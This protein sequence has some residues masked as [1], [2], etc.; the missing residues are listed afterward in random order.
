MSITTSPDPLSSSIVFYQPYYVTFTAGT[1]LENAGTYVYTTDWAVTQQV[2]IGGSTDASIDWIDLSVRT[3]PFVRQKTINITGGAYPAGHLNSGRTIRIDWSYSSSY[4]TTS[5]FTVPQLSGATTYNLAPSGSLIFT[6]NATAISGLPLITI[7]LS[8]DI[9][10]TPS[11]KGLSISITAPPPPNNY[12]AQAT[13]DQNPGSSVFVVDVPDGFSTSFAKTVEESLGHPPPFTVPISSLKGDGVTVVSTYNWILDFVYP[14]VSV[15]P[16]LDTLNAYQPFSHTF[17]VGSI[18]QITVTQ[19]SDLLDYFT[20]ADGIITLS[21]ARGITTPGTYNFTIKTYD[22][23]LLVGTTSYSLTVSLPPSITVNGP[24]TA[25]YKYE[26]FTTTFSLPDPTSLTLRYSKTSGDLRTIITQVSPSYLSMA[27]TFQTTTTDPYSLIVEELD[28]DGVVLSTFSSL[29]TVGNGRFYP[30]VS[31]QNYQLYQFENISN[32]LGSN[33]VFS[34]KTPINFIYSDVSLPIG[35]SFSNI[36]S[37]TYVLKGTPSISNA[38]RN[39]QIFGSNS[40]TGKIVST[41]ISINVNGQ[42]VRVTPTS[43]TA[44][45]L[46]VG[47]PITPITFTSI[48]PTTIYAYTFDYTWDTLPGGLVFTDINSNVVSP[49]F[50]PSDPSLTIVLSGTPTQAGA[51][52]L[53]S[54]P[55]YQVRLTGTRGD[56]TGAKISG[57][58]LI[59]FS[60]N[61]TVLISSSI[62]TNLYE[63]IPLTITDST[64]TPNTYF[65]SGLYPTSTLTVDSLPTGLSLAPSGSNYYL[66]GTPTVPGSNSYTFRATNTNGISTSIQVPIEIKPDTPTFISPTPTSG[67]AYTLIVSRPVSLDY[68]IVFSATSPLTTTIYPITYSTSIDLTAYGLTVSTVGT[69]YVISGIPTSTLAGQTITIT[70]TDRIGKTATT[71]I[72]LTINQDVFTWPSYT[73]VYYQNRKITSYQIVVSTASGRS[74]Q[75]FSS[76]NMPAGLAISPIGTITGTPTGT[77]S[78]TFSIFATTGYASPATATQ[79]FT[80]TLIQ[81]NILTVQVHDSDPFTTIFSNVYFNSIIYSSNA[82]VNPT[83]TISLYPNQVSPVPTLTLDSSGNL[84]G[85]FTGVTPY[86]VY[87]AGVTAT[88]GYVTGNT[89]ICLTFSNAPTPNLAIGYSFGGSNYIANTSSYVYQVTSSGTKL[90][91]AQVWTDS[92]IPPESASTNISRDVS[93][94][95]SNFVALTG[96]KVYDGTYNLTTQSIDWDIQNYYVAYSA[97]GIG[98]DGGNTWL[99]VSQAGPGYVYNI[100]KTTGDSWSQT[101]AYIVQG[102][103]NTSVYLTSPAIIKYIGANFVL[104][105]GSNIVYSNPANDLWNLTSFNQFNVSNIGI[106]N[107]TAVAVGG[108]VSSGSPISISTDS[109]NSWSQVT[110]T[111]PANLIRSGSSPTFADILYA[112]GTWV[113]CGVDNASSNFVAYTT[114]SSLTTWNLYIPATNWSSNIAWN[115]I[116]FNGNAWEIGGVYDFNNGTTGTKASRF[117]S[118]PVGTWP[119][120]TYTIFSN[121]L[122]SNTGSTSSGSAYSGLARVNRFVSS[123][124]SNGPAVPQLVFI[125]VNS[126]L[127]F[128]SPT[129]SNFLLYQYVPYTFQFSVVPKTEF[130]YYYCTDPP[131]G[132]EFQLDSEGKVATLTGIPPVNN[133]SSTITT[134]AKTLTKSTLKFTISLQTIFPFFVNPQVGAGA[135]TAILRNEVEA[136]AAQNAR[137][138]RTFPQVDPLAGPFMAPRAPDVTTPNDCFLKLCRKPCPT[139]HSM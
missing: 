112:N 96:T 91:N 104:A 66:T 70:A 3:S 12:L 7:S 55:S 75:S 108:S 113:M 19:T 133:T 32:T 69:T 29:V 97:L 48:L 54:S 46:T 27:G 47:T 126:D 87:S 65:Y 100:T 123:L 94:I 31:N 68:T 33:P 128:V 25:F 81:D 137:D 17:Y 61:E 121:T 99:I 114:D 106:S 8:D 2:F 15:T 119:P 93:S 127:S 116:N 44:T 58:S 43:A 23:T 80:F 82:I 74:I 62:S 57:S 22:G 132:F 59:G 139:C 64:L 30:P 83:Y 41:T 18:F 85:N 111:S 124:F 28:P 10:N 73:P 53:A 49:G 42:I 117:L 125:P 122:F 135:Y 36:D 63:Q 39:F 5:T 71:T 9:W 11:T 50:R 13:I 76:T 20:T 131:I 89:A 138:N 107:T 34:T 86:S 26:P 105:S 102:R 6:S 79:T 120:A 24:T 136:S 88:Y 115:S 84:S 77:T 129:Q 92:G 130:I 21:S 4:S 78:G 67:T 56:Q 72:Y 35:L 98:N 103:V 37:N 51:S 109:G 38:Q 45:G 95:G 52:T 134:Y 16:A 40:T 1:Y 101:T 118:V 14:S 110:I 60:F 90:S